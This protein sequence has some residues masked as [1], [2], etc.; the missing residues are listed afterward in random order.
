MKRFFVLFIS[1][2]L[3]VSCAK[4]TDTV[5]NTVSKADKESI[6]VYT[7]YCD[8]LKKAAGLSIT[9]NAKETATFRDQSYEKEITKEALLSDRGTE[10]FAAKVFEKHLMKT[11]KTELDHYFKQASVKAVVNGGTYYTYEKSAEDFLAELPI[12]PI[13]SALYKNISEKAAGTTT[14]LSFSA[15]TA[16]EAWALPEDASFKEASGKAS[17]NAEGRISKSSYTISYTIEDVNFERSY[18]VTTNL[19][20]DKA[21]S[22]PEADYIKVADIEAVKA[23][24]NASMYINHAHAVEFVQTIDVNLF[25]SDTFFMKRNAEYYKGAVDCAIIVKNSASEVTDG[26]TYA[27]TN[28]ESAYKNN[29]TFVNVDGSVQKQRILASNLISAY[30]KMWLMLTNFTKH[31][32]GFE[33]L[34]QDGRWHISFTLGD[35]ALEP[36]L[37]HIGTRMYLD[38]TAMTDIGEDYQ[39]K[40]CTGR[41]TIDAVTGLPTEFSIN[42]HLTHRLVGAPASA[43]PYDFIYEETYEMNLESKTAITLYD[44]LA[45]A[46]K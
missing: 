16:A 43:K 42:A 1:L 41:M 30:R 25:E 33:A 28:E 23:F 36:M 17:V 32:D 29:Y 9:V 38:Q 7:E 44:K 11:Q 3:L 2:S 37:G 8:K 21:P 26:K 46:D 24:E 31:T 39:W 14:E 10:N 34:L 45:A 22:A 40:S 12:V 35:A 15:P 13:N 6:D 4:S 20:S 27:V 5:T 18:T 19:S